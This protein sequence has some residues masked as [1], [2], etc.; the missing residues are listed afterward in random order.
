MKIKECF[1]IALT[2]L[3]LTSLAQAAV[4]TVVNQNKVDFV[5]NGRADLGAQVYYNCDSVEEYTK[6]ILSQMGATHI[7]VTCTGDFGNHLTDYPMVHA[8]FESLRLADPNQSQASGPM[9]D[10]QVLQLR[11]FDNCQLARAI[12]HGVK[13]SFEISKFSGD[14][15]CGEANSGYR[16]E[17]TILKAE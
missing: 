14:R 16:Y 3:G 12:V 5:V 13:D 9:A 4:P 1:A 7:S 11:D 17:L 6:N 15:M 10:W 8:Q 2:V